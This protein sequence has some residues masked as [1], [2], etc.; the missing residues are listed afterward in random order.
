MVTLARKQ[1]NMGNHLLVDWRGIDAQAVGYLLRMFFEKLHEPLI[2][3]SSADAMLAALEANAASESPAS[4]A[5]ALRQLVMA[6]PP[7]NLLVL[8]FTVRLLSRLLRPEHAAP[9]GGAE[10]ANETGD[11]GHLPEIV[12]TAAAGAGPA[13]GGG[14]PRVRDPGNGY[15]LESMAAAWTP[16]FFHCAKPPSDE[17][18]GRLLGVMSA[19]LAHRDIFIAVSLRSVDKVLTQHESFDQKQ[20]KSAYEQEINSVRTLRGDK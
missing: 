7:A 4:P 17:R 15:T 5:A 3:P 10:D 1:C 16:A 2:P 18:G 13:D 14:E 6:L 8:A 11:G 19:F 20:L 12:V 9:R